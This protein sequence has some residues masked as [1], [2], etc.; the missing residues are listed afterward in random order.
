[1]TA[2]PPALDAGGQVPHFT[3]T[4]AG[5]RRVSYASGIWQRKHLVLVTV[6][7]AQ[8]DEAAALARFNE[9]TLG[10]DPLD[11]ACVVTADDV[12]GLP[13]YGLLVADRWGEIAVVRRGATAAE[14]PNTDELRQWVAFVQQQCPECQGEAR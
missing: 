1:M 7:R 12:P 10:L 6:P 11:V 13:P 2:V 3:V 8:A 14:L 9:E 5:G 4:D